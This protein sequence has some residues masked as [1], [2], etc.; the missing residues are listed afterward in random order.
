MPDKKMSESQTGAGKQ[1]FQS[2][3]MVKTAKH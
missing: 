3:K 1:E 2:L